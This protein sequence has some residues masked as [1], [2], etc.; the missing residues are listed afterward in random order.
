MPDSAK[1]WKPLSNTI[2][3]LNGSSKVHSLPIKCPLTHVDQR[4]QRKS[5][6]NHTKEDSRNTHKNP[7]CHRDARRMGLGESPIQ[8]PDGIVSKE[9]LERVRKDL[10][11]DRDTSL[12]TSLFF[13]SFTGQ[14]ESVSI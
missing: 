1:H 5:T 3:I 2:K 10:G 12:Q 11:S 6:D 13:P 14:R 7:D 9:G 4:R 8:A